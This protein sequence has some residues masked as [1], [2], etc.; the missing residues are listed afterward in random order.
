V[1]RRI[2]LIAFD[3]DGTLLDRNREISDRNA[4]ALRRA[5][6]EGLIVVL[7]S[8]RAISTILPF[9]EQIGVVGPV[10]SCNGAFVVDAGRREVFHQGLPDSARRTIFD[11]AAS[12]GVH[13]NLYL[14]SEVHFTSLGAFG[15]EYVRRTRFLQ[16]TV[17]ALEVMRGMEATKMLFMDTT[18]VIASHTEQMRA[19]LDPA[20][21]VIALSEADYVEFLPPG[22]T[23]GRGLEELVTSMGIDRSEVAA[24]GDYWNDLEMVEWAGFGGAVDNAVSGVKEAAKVIVA[25][26]N[27]D[28]AAEFVEIVLSENRGG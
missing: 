7:A 13:L 26:H 17:S 28:G 1:A 6:A 22:V 27:D 15:Q 20:E 11:F 23:K 12:S 8:G 21:A 9:A 5:E 14:R 4:A 24:I 18:E 16:P 19:Q 2:K 25:D 10:V 3:L